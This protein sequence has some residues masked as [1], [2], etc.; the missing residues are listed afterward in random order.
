M[1]LLHSCPY[2]NF[3]PRIPL[4]DVA[5]GRVPGSH[6]VVHKSPTVVGKGKIDAFEGSG[7]DR[8]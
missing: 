5:L 7:R 1:R 4:R 6:K 3:K 2:Q 8:N